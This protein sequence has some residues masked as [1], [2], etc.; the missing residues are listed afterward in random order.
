LLQ[1]AAGNGAVAALLGSRRGAP[2][3]VQRTTGSEIGSWVNNQLTPAHNHLVAALAPLVA[4]GA[5]GLPEVG[6]AEKLA[7]VTQQL[8][9]HVHEVAYGAGKIAKRGDVAFGV[10]EVGAARYGADVTAA[11][12]G[13]AGTAGKAVQHKVVST[14][15]PDNVTG[16]IVGADL[17]LAGGTKVE[18]ATRPSSPAGHLR[19]LCDPSN[20]IR[21]A[22]GTT[23]T[24][25]GSRAPISRTHFTNA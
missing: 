1:T 7:A 21:G 22:A 16:A 20:R 15:N 10:Y 9:G 23:A 19:P 2:L 3:V 24:S 14:P 12:K 4:K 17:Q 25:P 18:R 6:L 13:G 5:A 11:R 8:Y